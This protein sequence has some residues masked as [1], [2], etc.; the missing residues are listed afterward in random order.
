M[1]RHAPGS[2]LLQRVFEIDAESSLRDS[3]HP[4]FACGATLVAK[5]TNKFGG[6]VLNVSKT[7]NINAVGTVAQRPLIFVAGHHAI[8]AT[9][10]N[11]VHN[12]VTEFSTGIGETI[13]KF[14]GGGIEEQARGFQSRSADKNDASTEFERLLGLRIDYIHTGHSARVRIEIDAAYDTVRT[15]GEAASFLGRRQRRT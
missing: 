13:G 15:N 2:W 7:R 4:A 3:A 14:G 10:H 5:A 8:G 6:F 1:Q 11:V 12:V 9:A